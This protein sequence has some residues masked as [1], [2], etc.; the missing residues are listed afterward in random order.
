VGE[1]LGRLELKLAQIGMTL[2]RNI[3]AQYM[4]TVN[5]QTSMYL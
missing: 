3:L 4:N 5:E 2:D 1:E